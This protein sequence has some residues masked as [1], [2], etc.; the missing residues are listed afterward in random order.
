MAKDAGTFIDGLQKVLTDVA[1]L[2]GLPDSDL[3]FLSQLQAMVVSK[4]RAVPNQMQQQQQGAPT[5][6]IDPSGVGGLRQ[7]AAMPP[8]D[9][10]RRMMAGTQ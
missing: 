1:A 9:E 6:G 10:L 3:Q 2:M 7:E 4:L 5:G 8:V